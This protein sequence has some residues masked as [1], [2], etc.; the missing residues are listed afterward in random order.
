MAT[1][2]YSNNQNVFETTI[3]CFRSLNIV[4]FSTQNRLFCFIEDIKNP[5]LKYAGKKVP[6]YMGEKNYGTIIDKLMKHQI[7]TK[8]RINN[9]IKYTVNQEKIS[10]YLLNLTAKA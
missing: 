10:E 6:T 8:S 4:S 9:R 5:Q 1:K 7:L 3:S 2:F